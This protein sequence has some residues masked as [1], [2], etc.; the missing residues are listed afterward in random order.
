MLARNTDMIG[1]MAAMS[2][3]LDPALMLLSE[4]QASLM[5]VRK[6]NAGIVDTIGAFSLENERAATISATFATDLL[7]KIEAYEITSRKALVAAQAAGSAIDELLSLPQPLRDVCLDAAGETGWTFV[8]PGL[9]SM[10][11]NTG[12][13]LP[14]RLLRIEPGRGA[15]NHD[16]TGSEYTLVVKGAFCDGTG[17]FAAGDLSIKRPGQIHHPIAQGNE[18]CFA[19]T[20]EEGEIAFTGALGLLQRLFTRH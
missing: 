4:T 14:A 2:G 16:H 12:G 6:G 7:A 18:P 1:L 10:H 5:G 15:P 11:L 17:Y 3:Q 20:V 8:G 19:L 13:A 9:K